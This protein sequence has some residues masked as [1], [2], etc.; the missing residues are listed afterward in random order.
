[1]YI[2]LHVDFFGQ[3]ES[4]D[5][6]FLVSRILF[7]ATYETNLDYTQLV[8]EHHLADNINAATQRHASRYTQPRQQA[9][10]HA[11]PMDLMALS[12][13]LKLIFNI[14]HFHP[15]LSQHF[16]LSIPNI[17]KIITQR[18]APSKPLDAP[19]SFLINALLN[20]VREEGTGTAQQPHDPE[21]HA[22]VFPS[23]NPARNATH[24]VTILDSSIHAYAATELDTTIS[25]LLTLLR[26]IYELAPADVRTVMQSKLLPSDSDR[27]QPLGKTT[28][29]PS[30]LLNLSTSAQTPALRDSIAAFMFELSS[31]DPATYV[32]NVGY[33]Y[34]SG[35]LLSK[36]IPMPESAIKDAGEG[37]S[38]GV[39]VNPIT[40]QRLDREEPVEMPEMTQEEKER[41]AERLFVLFERLKKTG[42]VNVKNPVEEAYRSGRIEELSDSE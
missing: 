15:D 34:A 8:N 19:V 37:S 21:L 31:K 26:R 25:P 3:S 1:M 16:T 14:T 2:F 29:L 33:G 17:F 36:N 20:L 41:E 12:E 27:T 4:I 24:L 38:S 7:L 28:S 42:V 22:A 18:D 6:E 23:V 40:G 5:D 30:R 13:T 10:E 32:S 39:P 11:A 35:F 9:Q